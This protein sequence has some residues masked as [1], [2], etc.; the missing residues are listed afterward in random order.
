MDS[1]AFYIAEQFNTKILDALYKVNRYG[2][3]AKLVWNEICTQDKLEK[4]NLLMSAIQSG[5]II[6]EEVREYVLQA[7]DLKPNEVEYNKAK[8]EKKKLEK[9]IQNKPQEDE[10]ED[11]TN[12]E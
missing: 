11:T 8:K 4:T 9:A 1:I 6:P 3:K 2:S 10:E 12:K 5:V 7:F